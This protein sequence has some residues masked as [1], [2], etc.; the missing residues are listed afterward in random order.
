MRGNPHRGRRHVP[1]PDCSGRRA[2]GDPRLAR[3][4][5]RRRREWTASPGSPGPTG[6]GFLLPNGWTV[7]PAGDQVTLTDLP[8]NIIPLD[9]GRH[10][11][12]ATSGYNA[13]ELS[14][15]DLAGKKV[16]AKLTV[17]QSWFGLAVDQAT[18]RVWWSGGGG[19]RVH[20]FLAQ[21]RRTGPDGEPEPAPRAE[22]QGT[23]QEVR[24]P[25][26][27]PQRPGARQ[28]RGQTSTPSTSTPARS[29]S[30]AS[31]RPTRRED[32]PGRRAAL[33]RRLRPQ[34]TPALRLRL[35][36]P[37]GRSRSTRTTSACWPRSPSASTRTRSPSTPTDDRIFVA[38][39]SS[40]CVSVIDTRRGVVTETIA[41]ALFP[42][43]PEG[44]TPDALAV[45]P[46]GKT[47]YVANADNNCVAV[48][49]VAAPNRSQVKGFIPTGWYPTA[50]AVTP[51]GKSLLV[52]V[53]KGNQTKAEPD[54]PEGQG[55]VRDR[56]EG[57]RARQEGPSAVSPTSARP[58]PGRSRSSPCPTT[59]QLAAY[60]ETVYK[61]C[62]YSDKLLTDAP[63]PRK[64][65][66]RRRSATRR[67]SST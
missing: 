20:A 50:V 61:N 59:R 5:R 25:E 43:A 3:G 1:T 9:D 42:L 16:V 8:L 58:S 6:K 23:G 67:R 35:G 36:Q 62:P 32:R 30:N 48:V 37:R 31:A 60:T 52:G 2:L 19:D 56:V 29:P 44:S 26:A 53:G 13:H 46:D 24:R 4:P 22:N 51:D 28:G 33:R 38:C 40:N 11:L 34:R 47:L 12:A 45:A 63:H 18:G 21:G 10:A 15:V 55:A 17:K 49:D 41:T 27:L 7:S 14:L 54:R 66:S 39:A 65:A 57:R 64:T